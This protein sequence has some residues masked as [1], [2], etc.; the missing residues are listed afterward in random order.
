[1]THHDHAHAS[2]HAP[3][4]ISHL[5]AGIKRFR[6]RFYEQNSELMPRL[7]NEARCRAIE[8]AA[9]GLKVDHVIVPGHPHC[10]GIKAMLGAAGD[11]WPERDFIGNRVS[12]ALDASR[13]HLSQ[14]DAQGRPVQA[15]LARLKDNPALVERASAPRSS[16]PLE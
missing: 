5:L 15:L 8:Y 1:M 7:G 6:Q 14:K 2:G 4:D 10:G 9:R 16:C 11:E 3:R 13:L 12:M